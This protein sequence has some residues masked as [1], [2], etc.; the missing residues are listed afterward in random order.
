M[1]MKNLLLAILLFG[2]SVGTATA[3]TDQAN[4]LDA[5]KRGNAKHA[6][7]KYEA[8]IEEYKRVPQSAGETYAQ[9]LYNIGV[10]YYELWRTEDA[11]ALYQRAVEARQGRYPKAL[12]A[13][14]V[15]LEDVG[16]LVEA[17]EAYKQSITAA[18]GADST[19]AVA[20]YRLGLLLAREGDYEGAA[21]LFREAIVR[22][23]NKF[24]ASHN[25]LGVM[26]ALAG[27][28]TEAE[29]EFKAALRQSDV[30]FEEAAHNLKLCR[31]LLNSPTKAQLAL[32]KISTATDIHTK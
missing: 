7:A 24:P 19:N 3:Q 1:K 8:A 11:I 31:S 2:L 4:A 15:A 6:A 28:L 23:D 20:H 22:A 29:R 21:T 14:G 30:A 13:M 10:C 17:K 18:G 25:N 12:Y 27:R 16:R 5:I 32:L 26:L 9:S